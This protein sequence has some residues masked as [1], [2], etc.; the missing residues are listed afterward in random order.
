M[1]ET[2]RLTSET[3]AVL[4]DNVTAI[5]AEMD[6]NTSYLYQILSSVESDPFAKFHR[7]YAASVRAGAPVY[8]WDDELQAIRERYASHN[9]NLDA[10]LAESIKEDAD[11]AIA[12]VN[13]RSLYEQL[14]EVDES[15][16]Q[17]GRL[18][19]AIIEAIN[20]EKDSFNGGKTR[21]NGNGI[22][23][24]RLAMRKEVRGRK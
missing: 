16:D 15:I 10:E 19:T 12:H 24:V 14:K 4:T 5:A 21:V 17:K 2:Y 18:R 13:G 9:L 11:V 22:P 3:R 6:V 7:I 1:R 8:R 20:A 23:A